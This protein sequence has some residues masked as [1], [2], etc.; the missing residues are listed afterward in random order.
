MRELVKNIKMEIVCTP[1]HSSSSGEH[2]YR[3]TQKQFQFDFLKFILEDN[4]FKFY[5]YIIYNIILHS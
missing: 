5:K 3:L 2:N 4:L 1:L